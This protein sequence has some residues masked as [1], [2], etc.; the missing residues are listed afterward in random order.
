MSMSEQNRYPVVEDKKNYE[1]D[2]RK[3]KV[4][5]WWMKADTCNE[6]SGTF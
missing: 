3:L 4:E 6:S 1:A 5:S 2:G